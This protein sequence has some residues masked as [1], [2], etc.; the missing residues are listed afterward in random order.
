MCVC[1]CVCVC[2]GEKEMLKPT[3]MGGSWSKKI[4]KSLFGSDS[5]WRQECWSSE[6]NEALNVFTCQWQ[7]NH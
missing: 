7:V 2:E 1:V 4:K 3:A 6:L 5:C